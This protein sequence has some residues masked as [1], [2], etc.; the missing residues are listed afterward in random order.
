MVQGKRSRIRF[1]LSLTEVPA[2]GILQPA[3]LIGS[4]QP[5]YFCSG[6]RPPGVNKSTFRYNYSE[7]AKV[8]VLSILDACMCVCVCGPQRYSDTFFFAILA[9]L[10]ITHKKE[11]LICI[12]RLTHAIRDT[13][14]H[15]RNAHTQYTTDPKQNPIIQNMNPK[16]ELSYLGSKVISAF[17]RRQKH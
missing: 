13:H 4:V 17:R 5:M 12:F 11:F 10:F 15:A 1:F 7:T 6:I 14:T 3:D 16:C 2:F 8:C 9:R